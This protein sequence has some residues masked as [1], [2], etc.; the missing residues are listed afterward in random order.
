MPGKTVS[1]AYT[2]LFFFG[3]LAVCRLE[4]FRPVCWRN[5]LI[6]IRAM[7]LV[8]AGYAAISGTIAL[9]RT[10]AYIVPAGMVW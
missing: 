2:T 10:S 8:C 6:V 4:V 1:L 5:P 9:I 3:G 7:F